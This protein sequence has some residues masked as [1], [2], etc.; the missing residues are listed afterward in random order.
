MPLGSLD[1]WSERVSRSAPAERVVSDLVP[2]WT[3]FEVRYC[4]AMS[5]GVRQESLYAPSIA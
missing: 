5:K 2:D 4:R 1:T 3:K